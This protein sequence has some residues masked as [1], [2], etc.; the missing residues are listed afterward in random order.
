[1]NDSIYHKI[2]NPETGRKVYLFGNGGKRVLNGYLRHL[3]NVSQ[4]GGSQN[5]QNLTRS[6]IKSIIENSP[7]GGRWNKDEI[8]KLA[9][10]N[11]NKLNKADYNGK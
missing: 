3:S 6:D 11:I 5:L 10:L 9:S 1:M 8:K 7:P 4:T 2:V